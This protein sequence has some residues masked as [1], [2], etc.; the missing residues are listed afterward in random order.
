[1]PMPTEP[2]L[3]AQLRA[4]SRDQAAFAELVRLFETQ[5][6]SETACVPLED[7]R[8]LL[9]L[10][11]A[12]GALSDLDALCRE[13]VAQGAAQLGFERLRLYL[14]N[15]QK[16]QLIGTYSIDREGALCDERAFA[17]PLAQATWHEAVDSAPERVQVWAQTPLHDR[18][19][20]LGTGWRIAAALHNGIDTLGYLLADN[21]LSQC[22]PRPQEQAL[23][24][25]YS[26]FLAQRIALLQTKAALQRLQA[27][28]QTSERLAAIGTWELDL[29][30]QQ[31]Y[32]S[33]QVYHLHGVPVGQQPDLESAINFYPPE[34]R[35]RIAAVIQ[36]AQQEGIGWD[37][38]VPFVNAK[39]QRLWVRVVGMAQRDADGVI[40]RL[41]GFFQ[42]LTVQRQAQQQALDLAMEREKVR[43]LRDFLRDVSHDFRTPFTVQNNAL[44][45]INHYI[46]KLGEQLK[47]IERYSAGRLPLQAQATLNACHE[48]LNQIVHQSEILKSGTR[49]AVKLLDQLLDMAR[50]ENLS[51][52]ERTPCDLNALLAQIV[53]S[54]VPLMADKALQLVF[55][56]A[57]ALPQIAVNADLFSRA[58][59][60]LLDNAMQ[61]TPSGGTVCLRTA[62]D[63]QGILIEIEDNGVGIPA[64]D[65]PHI[66]KRF[67]RVDKAR[68]SQ[69]GGSGL[70]LAIVK[71]VI[72]AHGGTVSA[73]SQVGS[74]ALFRLRLPLRA[75]ASANIGS[76]SSE[77]ES[78]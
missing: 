56:P 44:Y 24:S 63:D 10:S 40:R 27:L 4:H 68:A 8:K 19:E 35:P 76:A 57:Q 16:A 45:L 51:A 38:E 11:Q 46:Q 61:Y 49:R 59:H 13:A 2:D 41:Y 17:Q 28:Q 74:G 6:G 53:E 31:P 70:G 67:Y 47:A 64:E 29:E 20:P 14:L 73:Q 55:K 21:P 15:P 23:L 42:D 58:I 77:S 1:M 5:T 54:Y 25:L 9:R 26:H 43:L 39:G 30:K 66:F 78:R 12:L 22:P 33:E 18:D 62:Q 52:L 60:N 72:E 3:L 32:W 37:M 36:R 50:A 7:F 75:Q 48:L 34:A 69:S 65:L 71:Q